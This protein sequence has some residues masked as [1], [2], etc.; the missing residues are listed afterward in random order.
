M[1]RE[2][3][4]TPTPTPENRLTQFLE[5]FPEKLKEILEQAK[6]WIVTELQ[7]P[8]PN[9]NVINGIVGEVL[10]SP[11]AQPDS[12]GLSHKRVVIVSVLAITCMEERLKDGGELANSIVEAQYPDVDRTSSTADYKK[13]EKKEI[14]RNLKESKICK[15]KN[16]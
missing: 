16:V 8:D 1:N 2:W 12:S 11:E 4:P 3:K 15:E 13:E 6:K 10:K 9:L 7:K 5:E 14:L